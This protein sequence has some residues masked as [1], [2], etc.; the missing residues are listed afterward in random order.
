MI[1]NVDLWIWYRYI[2]AALNDN[3]FDAVTTSGSDPSLFQKR[4]WT[5]DC[6]LD[7]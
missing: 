2:K 3:Y 5:V 1:R 4:V 6:L 7:E